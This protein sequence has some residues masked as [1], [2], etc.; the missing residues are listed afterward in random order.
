MG[1]TSYLSVETDSTAESLCSK[2]LKTMD[3][4]TK[5]IN[6]I[7]MHHG[8]KHYELILNDS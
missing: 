4:F 3:N 1:P 8:Q 2:G 5:I 7:L 6:C